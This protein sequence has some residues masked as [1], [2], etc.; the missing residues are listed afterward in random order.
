MPK[1]WCPFAKAIPTRSFGYRK[2]RTGQNKPLFFVDHIIGGHKS[3]L[4]HPDYWNNSGLSTTFAIGKDG[5]ISQYVS[6]FDAHYGNGI[7]GKDGSGKITYNLTNNRHL[8]AL[9]R[10]GSWVHVDV[11]YGNGTLPYGS[12]VKGGVSMLNSH[13]ISTE[14]DG[15]TGTRWTDEM[16]ASDIRVKL[17]CLKELRQ[18][19]IPMDV[20]DDMLVSHKQIDGR[21]RGNCPGT[22]WARDKILAALLGT[23]QPEQEEEMAWIAKV[24]RGQARY[25]VTIEN[26]SMKKK[27]LPN[28]TVRSDLEKLLGTETVEV[29]RRT[30]NLMHGDD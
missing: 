13:S 24:R 29:D 28:A 25:L 19:G 20:D 26:G 23:P 27:R 7:S 16:V 15:F 14:H 11:P 2:G 17:W 1:G 5:L 18:Y 21:H 4:D 12:L 6:I 8:A 3:T 10:E 22:G 9:E 30:L